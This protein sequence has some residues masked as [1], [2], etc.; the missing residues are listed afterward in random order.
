MTCNYCGNLIL[1]NKE[2]VYKVTSVPTALEV[3]VG[4][5][6]R[7]YNAVDCP[8]CGC[9]HIL[10]EV[11]ANFKKETLDKPDTDKKVIDAIKPAQPGAN[12]CKCK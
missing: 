5:K 2:S 3:L 9:Q 1:I 7:L 12:A 11:M 8:V 6:T 4:G 10:Q